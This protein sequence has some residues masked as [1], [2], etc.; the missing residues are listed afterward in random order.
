MRNRACVSLLGLVVL[1]AG[2]PGGDPTTMAFL[3]AVAKMSTNPA[4][5]PIGSLTALEWKA[6]S[7]RLSEFAPLVGLPLPDGVDIPVLTDEQAEDIVQFL[8]EHEAE[9][10][11]DVEAL[12][13]ESIVL[14]E[15]LEELAHA[16]GADLE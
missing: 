15:S 6:V 5:P 16:F 13:Y 10:V 8:D 14:P 11:S 4:D 3:S 9:T 2:C 1:L 12:D 7:A